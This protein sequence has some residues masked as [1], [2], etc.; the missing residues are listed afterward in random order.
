MPVR[1]SI[2][3]FIDWFDPGYKAGG[4]IRS[5][6]NFTKHLQHQFD[7]FVFTSDRDLGA[8]APYAGISTDCWVDYDDRAKVFYCSPGH[9]SWRTI[10]AAIKDVSPDH[11]YLNSL[12][13]TFFTIYPLLISKWN[14]WKRP[15]VLAPRGMLRSSA[16]AFKSPKKKIFLRAFRLLNLHSHITFQATDDTELTDVGIHFGPSAKVQKVVNLAAYVPAFPGSLEKRPGVLSMIFVGRIHPIKNLDFLLLRLSGLSGKV[17]LTVVG[18]DEDK[19]FAARCKELA[20][21]LPANIAVHFAG[22]KPNHELPALIAMHHIFCLPTQ[23][24]NFGH[25]IFEGLSA[26]KPVLISDQTPWLGLAARKA[27]WD[28]SLADPSGFEVALLQALAMEQ[29]EYNEWSEGAWQHAFQFS[30]G[31]DTLS[32]YITL[33]S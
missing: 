20:V 33:F 8:D 7:V 5:A 11:I 13:S 26:G 2:L 16:L 10:R 4:P 19:A 18:S 17:S 6:V 29:A 9:L 30:A 23:G 24:E 31:A 25:A 3:V 32:K 28:I 12:F 21:A 1:K 14:G 22:E 27:G 15:V